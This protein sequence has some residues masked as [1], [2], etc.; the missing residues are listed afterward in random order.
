MLGCV[1]V[2]LFGWFLK[3]SLGSLL[4]VLFGRF[5]VMIDRLFV[6]LFVLLFDCVVDSLIV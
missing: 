6:C 2:S 5:G 4:V 3:L 1:F